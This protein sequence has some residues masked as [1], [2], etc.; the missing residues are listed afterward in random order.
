MSRWRNRIAQ[1]KEKI[2]ISQLLADYGYKVRS[3]SGDREQ[4]FPCD[5]HGDG[6]DNKPS[7]RAYPV[8]ASWYCWACSKYRDAIE[9]VREKERKKDGSGLTF[10]EAIDFLEQKY[11]LPS[12]PWDDEDAAIAAQPR[13][14]TPSKDQAF[15]DGRS[16][17]AESLRLRKTLEWITKDREFPM[18]A[19]L[20]LWETLDGIDWLLEE[21]KLSEPKA[22]EALK[23]VSTR[24]NDLLTK[25]PT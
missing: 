12:V 16:F 11:G 2:P 5:L 20:T 3:D 17:A 14:P 1:I 15:A 13:E 22:R 6:R 19:V 23:I 25:E 9:T 8:S 7:G 18:D 21:E 10:R 24:I 4:Q